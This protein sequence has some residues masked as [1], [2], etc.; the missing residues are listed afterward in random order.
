[1]QSPQRSSRRCKGPASELVPVAATT[2]TEKFVI[3]VKANEPAWVS[4]TADVK[5][6]FEGVLKR[7]KKTNAYSQV[8]IVKSAVT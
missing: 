8:V 2:G 4:V 3:L 7:K 6:F 5:P 1:M